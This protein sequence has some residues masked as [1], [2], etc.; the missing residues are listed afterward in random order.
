MDLIILKQNF[1]LINI[2]EDNLKEKV[3]VKFIGTG[4]TKEECKL[5]SEKYFGQNNVSYTNA[6]EHKFLNE[7]YNSLDLFVLPSSWEVYEF[8]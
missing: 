2:L 8:I 5:Y 3:R 4:P 6:M 1:C 7:F